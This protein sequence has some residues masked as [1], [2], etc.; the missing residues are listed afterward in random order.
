[1]NAH[2]ALLADTC[3]FGKFSID[4]APRPSRNIPRRNAL[5]RSEAPDC[6]YAWGK[7]DGLHFCGITHLRLNE[8]E[9]ARQHLTAA[10]EI[11]TRLGHGRI[12]ET[13]RTLEQIPPKQ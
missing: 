9:L 10:L 4:L 3:G 13:R 2:W 1:M 12:E 6:H 11:R 8:T 5:H 7:A